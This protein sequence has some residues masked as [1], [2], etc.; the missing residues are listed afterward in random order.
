MEDKRNLTDA[1]V[2]AIVNALEGKLYVKLRNNVGNGVL[3][4]V[5]RGF[6]LGLIWLAAYGIAKGWK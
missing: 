1:D 3:S 4:L 6:I 5:W 2:E